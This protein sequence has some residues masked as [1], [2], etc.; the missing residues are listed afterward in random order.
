[1]YNTNTCDSCSFVLFWISF[2]FTHTLPSPPPLTAPFNFTSL[3]AASSSCLQAMSFPRQTFPLSHNNTIMEQEEAAVAGECE[4]S[5]HIRGS[6][7]RCSPPRDFEKFSYSRALSAAL[8]QW[9]G[10]RLY[11]AYMLLEKREPKCYA[12]WFIFEAKK[13][14]SP[15]RFLY[16][17]SLSCSCSMLLFGSVHVLGES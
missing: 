13:K 17:F 2:S 12:C 6:V 9:V 5:E 15:T 4:T 1:M 3:S 10:S 14:P 16:M 7:P 8:Y 11:I